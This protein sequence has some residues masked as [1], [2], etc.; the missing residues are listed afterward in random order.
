MAYATTQTIS[1]T[2]NGSGA[3]TSYSGMITGQIVRIAYT[4]DD[5]ASGVDFTITTERDGVTVWTEANVNASEV[6]TPTT[7]TQTDVG[8]DASARDFIW[9]ADDRLKIVIANGG[10][11]KVGSFELVVA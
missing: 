9:V 7:L 3:A 5:F 8:T 1:V 2:T 4:K 6:V 11:A 10:A